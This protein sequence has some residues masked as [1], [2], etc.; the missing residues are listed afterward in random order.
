MATSRTHK[1][2]K[3]VTKKSNAS[4]EVIDLDDLDEDIITAVTNALTQEETIEEGETCQKCCS[5]EVSLGML[6]F[7]LKKNKDWS[8]KF[9]ARD[10]TKQSNTYHV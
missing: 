9:H 1:T 10:S 4:M 2:F 3:L 8:P 7:G 6:N 5:K